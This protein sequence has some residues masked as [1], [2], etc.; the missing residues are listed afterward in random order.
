MP[1]PKLSTVLL[2]CLLAVVLSSPASA[3]STFR[4]GI[5]EPDAA[6]A[7]G[8]QYDA[9]RDANPDLSRITVYWSR[10]VPGGSQ[11]PAN[12]DARNP[13]D[14]G[15]DWGQ[16]DN[17]V[18]AMKSRGVEPF[19]TILEAPAWAEGD[20]AADRA[21]RF[22][23]AGTYRV[24]AKDVG[25]Y[26][27]AVATRYSGSFKD[28]NGNTLPRVKF[29]Q[30]WNEP[31]FAQYLV[32]R[33][34]ADIP[35]VYAKMLNAA[36]DE[37]KAVSRSNVVMTAGLGPY[38]NNG[39]ATDVEPQVFMRSLLCLTGRGG[40]KLRDNRR[41]KYPKAKFD[42]WTQHPYTF[43]GTPRTSAGNPDSAALGDMAAVRRTLDYAVKVRNVAG[44][45]RPA[46][47][48][49]EFGWFANPPGII[50][51]GRQ[52]GLPPA[53]QAA[54]LSETAYRLWK[55]RFG[56]MVWYG[57]HDQTTHEFPTGLYQGSFPGATPRPALDAFKFPFFADYTSRKGVLFWGMVH[58]G[59]K[60][61][62]RIEKQ[63]GSKFKR[64]VDL[65]TDSRGMFY[66]RVRVRKGTFRA[67][68]LNG[69]KS[70]ASSLTFKAR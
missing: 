21:K 7:D 37:V 63:S 46:L 44:K 8:G 61:T 52:L 18:R 11:K 29:F 34:K 69:G 56:A 48:V 22:G 15:Y 3:Y 23:D 10:M 20:D 67:T 49:T 50:G 4:L 28:A 68:A 47:W 65:R 42:V 40:R 16:L 58:K 6:G 14:A 30:I 62:V 70:G 32:S 26:M 17:F 51:G 27:H 64:V 2:G 53:K 66:S 5:H 13:A 9:L 25:D 31:N 55:L 38:G 1:F 41:C 35:K 45:R 33:R 36:Y 57:L 24:N 19:I 60:T 54:Y 12:F 43:G 59:G 39:A